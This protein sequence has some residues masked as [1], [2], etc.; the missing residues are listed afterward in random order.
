VGLLR[1]DWTS[2]VQTDSAYGPGLH[3]VGVGKSFVLFPSTQVNL[4]RMAMAYIMN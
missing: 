3:W 4:V 2:Y 1:N